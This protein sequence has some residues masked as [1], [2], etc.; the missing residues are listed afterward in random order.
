MMT[1]SLYELRSCL[2]LSIV[3]DPKSLNATCAT[4]TAHTA[5]VR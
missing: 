4:H 5:R 3:I 1:W 2:T